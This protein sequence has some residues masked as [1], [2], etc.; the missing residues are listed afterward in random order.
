MPKNHVPYDH[1]VGEQAKRKARNRRRHTTR[2]VG[3]AF[4]IVAFLG[5]SVG[6]ITASPLVRVRRV[7]IT[8]LG[9]VSTDEASATRQAVQFRPNTPL[10]R[11]PIAEVERAVQELPWVRKAKVGW[12]LLGTVYVQVEAREPIAAILFP[13]GE[14]WEVDSSGTAIRSAGTETNLPRIFAVADAEVVPGA[15]IQSQEAPSCVL[16][17]NRCAEEKAIQI[18]KITI[19]SQGCMWFNMRDGLTVEMGVADDIDAKTDLL[20]RIYSEEPGIAGR[21]ASINLQSVDSPACTPRST[22]STQTREPGK[23]KASRSK[24][25]SRE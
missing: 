13:N 10:V 16:A 14:A 17:I 6:A 12:N 11:A 20:K 1:K 24:L 19:D 9:S 3:M 5:A 25:S 21:V 7:E 18:D 15:P 23:T 4:A 8:G 2:R 22:S